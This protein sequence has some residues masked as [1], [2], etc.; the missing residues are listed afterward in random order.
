V[1]RDFA[2]HLKYAR[3]W[4]TNKFDGQMVHRDHVLEDGDVIELHV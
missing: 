4:G 3:I 2:L 1:H